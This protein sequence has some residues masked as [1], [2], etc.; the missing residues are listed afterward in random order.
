MTTAVAL[1]GV[2]NES[3][4]IRRCL[5]D[6]ISEGIDVILIDQESTDD[7]VAKAR[8]FL[9]NGLLSVERLKWNGAFS[10]TE[11]LS[12]QRSL[13]AAVS[14]D[15]VIHA[16]ADEWLC[17]PGDGVR[18]ID[19]I[20][21]AERAGF[22]CINFNEFAFIPV[23]G[24]S[25]CHEDY[26]SEM[27]SYYFIRPVP[28]PRLMRAWKR[29]S[30]L[31]NRSS[32]GHELS[33]IDVRLCDETFILRHYIVLGSD[34]AREKYLHRVF[35]KDELA[36]GW[37]GNRIHLTAEALEIRSCDRVQHLPHKTSKAFRTD[38]PVQE[39]YWAWR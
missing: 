27:L 11:Q 28:T 10:M 35:A 22:N 15:W 9:G 5:R 38:L 34:H 17:A 2:R 13:A 33:G 31:D 20:A 37:H 30:A 39:H 6:F 25:H 23:V 7:T 4:H 29:E 1:L 24:R 12:A 8:E 21:S 36:K 18:L 19:G 3:V 14:H 16:S 26:S 32:A